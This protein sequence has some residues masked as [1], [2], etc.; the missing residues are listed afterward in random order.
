MGGDPD[1]LACA[2][3]KAT[4]VLVTY[5]SADRLPACLQ[6][7][8]TFFDLDTDDVIVVDNNS[9]DGS[10]AVTRRECPQARVIS[11]KANVG[12][13]RAVNQ[14]LASGTGDYFALVNPD[15]FDI[16]GT[17]DRVR[18]LLEDPGVAAVAVK[19]LD[20][21]GSLQRTCRTMSSP[22][23]I[24]AEDIAP[25]GGAW[26]RDTVARYRMLS[27]DMADERDVEEAC[28]ALLFL[29]AR[30]VRLLGPLDERYFLY[31]EE[32]DWLRRAMSAGLR[33]VYT[34]T[35]EAVHV[36]GESAVQTEHGDL[37]LLLAD[38]DF[39][40]VRKW[41]GIP[42]E[43][44]MRAFLTCVD[45]VRALSRILPRGPE[46]RARALLAARR[47]KVDLGGRAPRGN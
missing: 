26:V 37:S 1:A 13:A 38:S 27:W 23:T 22:A 44:G 47:L 4:V 15:V 19:L 12:F 34:P 32:T 21:D 14:A 41:Y 31:A 11:N 40:Y 8:R 10:I 20:V 36:G 18:T 6:A 43:L 25:H 28:G 39:A 2:A 46:A 24:I 7:V 45:M 5:N 42:A 9:S 3:L 29:S 16:A 33:T 35:V 30:A 17:L